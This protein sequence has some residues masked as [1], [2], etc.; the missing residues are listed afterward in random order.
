MAPLT[1]IQMVVYLQ[2]VDLFA[3]CSAEQMVRIAGIAHQERFEAGQRIYSTNDPA[4]ALY[5]VVEGEVSIGGADGEPRIIGPRGTFGVEAILSDRLRSENARAVTDTAALAIEA[6]DFFDLLSNNIEIVKALFR[7]LLRQPHAT[8]ADDA[9]TRDATARD[10]DTDAVS[11]DVSESP[12]E[13][14]ALVTT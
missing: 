3:Y 7:Q 2:A 8:R 12:D 5:C 13:S 11:R 1:R 4:D 10:T 14:P 9:E 6:D